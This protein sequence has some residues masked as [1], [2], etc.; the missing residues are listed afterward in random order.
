MGEKQ[1]SENDTLWSKKE[2]ASYLNVSVR[3]IDHYVFSK[4][5]PYIKLG[6]HIR[7]RFGDIRTWLEQNREA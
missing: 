4:Q 2:L 6:K 5:V 3:T 1:L 7:F